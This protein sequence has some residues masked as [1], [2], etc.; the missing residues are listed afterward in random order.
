MGSKEKPKRADCGLF[1]RGRQE[2]AKSGISVV[3]RPGMHQSALFL[4][5]A[6][7]SEPTLADRS[8]QTFMCEGPL[9]TVYKSK[10]KQ[11]V[12]LTLARRKWAR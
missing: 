5:E 11:G 3:R 12:P 8:I 6:C 9:P 10:I 4:L 1:R 2:T 7:S